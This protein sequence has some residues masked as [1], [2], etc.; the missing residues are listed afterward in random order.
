MAVRTRFAPSPTGDLHLGG[1]WTALASWVVARRQPGGVVALRIEDIDPPRV[2]A[3]ADARILDDL[4]W[5]GLDWDE[6]PVRQSARTRLYD[7]AVAR[8][9]AEDLVYPCDCSRTDIARAASAPH[10][11]EELVYPGTC[12]D[13]DPDRAMKRAPA[14]RVRVPDLTVDLRRR[15]RR[16]A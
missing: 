15:R 10:P 4:R 13:L 6:G 9:A 14:L 11:G 16:P 3:D 12:R 2:V 8:L 7:A 1:A 5:L